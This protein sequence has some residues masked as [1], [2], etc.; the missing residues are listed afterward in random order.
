MVGK[1]V[2]EKRDDVGVNLSDRVQGIS[3]GPGWLQGKLVT[4]HW[5]MWFGQGVSV[6]TGQLLA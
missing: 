3:E 1:N 5:E 4:L 2:W 6:K